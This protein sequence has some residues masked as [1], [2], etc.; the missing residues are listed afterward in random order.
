MKSLYGFHSNCNNCFFFFK[1]SRV[2]QYNKHVPI[3]KNIKKKL[4]TL[5]VPRMARIQ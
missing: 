3:N 5:D 1:Q 4:G 2:W